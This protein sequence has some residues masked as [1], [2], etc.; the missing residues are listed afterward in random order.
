MVWWQRKKK[1][2]SSALS[3]SRAAMQHS[4]IPTSVYLTAYDALALLYTRLCCILFAR[5][6]FIRRGDLAQRIFTGT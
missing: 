5:E 6:R 1:G 4:S 3:T 2:N